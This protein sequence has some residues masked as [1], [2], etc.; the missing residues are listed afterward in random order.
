MLLWFGGFS[1]LVCMIHLVIVF[2]EFGVCGLVGVL[3]GFVD[4]GLWFGFVVVGW[5]IWFLSF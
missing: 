5:W 2:L 3:F 1:R 4:V